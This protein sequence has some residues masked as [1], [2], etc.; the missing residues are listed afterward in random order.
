MLRDTDDGAAQLHQAVVWW[1]VQRLQQQ[2][3]IYSPPAARSSVTKPG[4]APPF[5]FNLP[6]VNPLNKVL[7]VRTAALGSTSRV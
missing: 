3:F 4:A 6:A 1:L 2:R 7:C 5:S